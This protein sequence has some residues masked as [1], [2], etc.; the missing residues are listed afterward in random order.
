MPAVKRGLDIHMSD[1][2]KNIWLG[3]MG[4]ALILI[5]LVGGIL[6]VNKLKK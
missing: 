2:E 6:V 5:I 3:A 4:A 1:H